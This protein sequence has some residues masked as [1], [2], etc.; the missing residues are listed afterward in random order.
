LVDQRVHAPSLTIPIRIAAQSAE[1]R[2]VIMMSLLCRAVAM[3]SADMCTYGL[4]SMADNLCVWH[5]ARVNG[6]EQ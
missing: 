3:A 2:R 4:Q 1:F 6:M 5:F